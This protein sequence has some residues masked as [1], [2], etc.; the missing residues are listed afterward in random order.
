M[1]LRKYF[2]PLTG[3]LTDH[4]KILKEAYDCKIPRNRKNDHGISKHH[5]KLTIGHWFGSETLC[6]APFCST[7]KMW[8]SKEC[9]DPFKTAKGK[10]N[11]RRYC[12]ERKGVAIK[13]FRLDGPEELYDLLDPKTYDLKIIRLVRDPR[14]ML[15]SRRSMG[16]AYKNQAT[17][18]G[19]FKD[20]AKDLDFFLDSKIRNNTLFV[21]YEDIARS[22][23]EYA[24]KIYSHF[25]IPL[26]KNF[27]ENFENATH[28]EMDKE[29]GTFTVNKAKNE[30]EIF[31]GWRRKIGKLVKPQEIKEI[32]AKC[33]VMMKVF[34]YKRNALGRN[35]SSVEPKMKIIN[36]VV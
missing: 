8:C 33:K 32:E 17:I 36:L 27:F 16:R 20:C 31:D 30:S 1:S 25:Q 5:L 6:S 28:A 35:I 24:R 13:E 12:R 10:N 21:R 22:P 14:S 15:V 34:G 9:A 19:I 18:E 2:E 3:S 23:I 11:L 26:N 29:K 7:G 4:T